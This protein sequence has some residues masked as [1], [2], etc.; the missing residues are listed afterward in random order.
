MLIGS[1]DEYW[2]I[3]V[4]VNPDPAL[5]LADIGQTAEELVAN[6]PQYET[7]MCS[8]RNIDPKQPGLAEYRQAAIDRIM[9]TVAPAAKAAATKQGKNS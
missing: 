8:M 6:L 4:A 7:S 3:V 5:V 2:T 1:A 9:S